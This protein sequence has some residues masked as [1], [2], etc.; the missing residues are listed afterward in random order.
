LPSAYRERLGQH[1]AADTSRAAD[2]EFAAHDRQGRTGSIR[3]RYQAYRP[4]APDAKADSFRHSVL[5]I[6]HSE[7]VLALAAV[8]LSKSRTYHPHDTH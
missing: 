3:L 1:H 7:F 2:A 6:L 4:R 5:C 8:E